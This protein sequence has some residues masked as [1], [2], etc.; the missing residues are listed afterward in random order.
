VKYLLAVLGGFTLTLCV[1][2]GGAAFAVAY[3]TAERPPST[4]DASL[5]FSASAVSV[6]TTQQDFERIDAQPAVQPL[7]QR[8]QPD[9][10]IN[11][12]TSA[13]FNE[14]SE[15]SVA[16]NN[17]VIWCTNRYRSYRPA[18]NSYTS[19]DG[20]QRECS[21]PFSNE[22]DV[23]SPVSGPDEGAIYIE[24]SMGGTEA[25][26]AGDL[27]HTE[28]CYSRYRS[29]RPEDNTYQPYGGGVRRQCQ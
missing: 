6:D 7:V 1:F 14:T 15:H 20:G 4:A 16:S 23:T 12:P 24:A 25:G 3:L 27:Q 8:L 2:M 21:S 28:Y 19:Y 17:H 5:T 9:V 22:T 26:Y 11:N 13:T 18:D 29:Y 10:D